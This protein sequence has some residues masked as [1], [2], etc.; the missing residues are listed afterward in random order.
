MKQQMLLLADDHIWSSAFLCT[1]LSHN[2]QYSVSEPFKISYPIG[3]A[4][5]HLIL[6]T[7]LYWR[8]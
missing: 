7:P 5:N 1:D 4:F 2:V 6:V 8:F 3:I